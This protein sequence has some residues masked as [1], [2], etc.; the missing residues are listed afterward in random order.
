MPN[1]NIP[2]FILLAL[3]CLLDAGAA[4][5]IPATVLPE[6]LSNGRPRGGM[7]RSWLEPRV[8]ATWEQWK[9]GFEARMENGGWDARRD[10]LRATLLEAIGQLP[11]ERTPLRARVTGVLTRP[12]YRVEKVVF[13]SLPGFFVTGALFI[14]EDANAASRVPGILIPCGHARPAKAHDEY[15]AAGALLALNGMVALVFDP[16]DQGERF[17]RLDEQGRPI[18]GGTA[19]H[20]QEGMAAS[21]LGWNLLRTEIWDGIRALDYLAGRPEVDASRLGITGNSGGGTQAA[22]VFALDER[23]S[24]AAPSCYIH[25]LH[26]QAWHELGDSEQ[27][28]FGQLAAGYEHAEFFLSRAP[29]P[30]LLLTATHD[31]FDIEKAWETF[32]FLQRRYADLGFSERAAIFENNAG[33]NYNRQQREAMARWMS[34]W[35]LGRDEP[36]REPE[37]ELFTEQELQA[38]PDGQVLLLDGARSL[39]DLYRDENARLAAE[40][41]RPS[42]DELRTRI[43]EAIGVGTSSEGTAAIRGTTRFRLEEDD[44]T[45]EAV[46]LEW[47]EEPLAV[48]V[49]IFE[50]RERRPGP[51]VL[52]GTSRPVGRLARDPQA[53]REWLNAGRPVLFFNPTGLG[54]S[55]QTAQ[56]GRGEAVG[57]DAKDAFAL[58]QLGSSQLVM[59]TED[60]LRVVQFVV[61]RG[62]AAEGLVELIGEEGAG[63]P[64]LH[65]AVLESGRVTSVTLRRSLQSWGDFIEAE[66]SYGVLDTIVHGVLRHYDLPD[67]VA[68]LGRKTRVESPVDAAGMEILSGDAALPPGFTEP[69]LAGLH[70]VYYGNTRFENAAGTETLERLEMTWDNA[71]QRRGNDWSGEWTGLLIGPVDGVVEFEGAS[72]R[73]IELLID[74]QTVLG[75]EAFPGTTRGRMEMIEGREYAVALRFVQAEGASGSLTI[76]WK[77]PGRP[78]KVVGP[79]ALRHSRATEREAR[80]A[81]VR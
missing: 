44:Y 38:T 21:L 58:Y 79:D 9:S 73:Q 18:I 42:A 64:V 1:Y 6:T 26:Y 34:R 40:R 17:Q 4:E 11:G 81:L 65:A 31:F 37:I 62:L 29:A 19:A 47:G 68:S 48:P 27:M 16:V 20:M 61:E 75:K 8:A 63:V 76:R 33:H 30:V 53:G 7:V 80:R 59:R 28:F 56:T 70:G 54:E 51:P 55:R 10:R 67:L 78:W 43:R 57:S 69:D 72:D 74:G 25:Q 46:M 50:P 15:Q 49:V 77:W 39:W 32:R 23:L 24:V 36:I 66:R 35:L 3:T 12:G 41:G 14:P 5:R 2:A 22:F 60:V 45:I 13:E 52:V 71:V